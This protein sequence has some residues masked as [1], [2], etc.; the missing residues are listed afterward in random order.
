MSRML[1]CW[2]Y[3]FKIS[4]SDT[5]LS[6]F[7]PL[8]A[9]CNIFIGLVLLFMFKGKGAVMEQLIQNIIL[10]L[11]PYICYFILV[12][13]YNLLKIPVELNEIVIKTKSANDIINQID[14]L[15]IEVLSIQDNEIQNWQEKAKNFIRSLSIQNANHYL[16]VFEGKIVDSEINSLRINRATQKLITDENKPISRSLKLEDVDTLDYQAFC[17][18]EVI[19]RKFLPFVFP[20]DRRNN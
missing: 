14:A 13:L 8:P 16:L 20:I 1:S 3:W 18:L 9:I 7:K 4:F 12:W 15:Q 10:V 5:K 6:L 2:M 17:V 19:K 11:I